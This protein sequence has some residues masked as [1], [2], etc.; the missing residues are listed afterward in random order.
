[1]TDRHEYC[2]NINI[3]TMQCVSIVCARCDKCTG[4]N[5]QGHYWSYCKVKQTNRDFH[6]CCPGDCELEND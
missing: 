1:M 5:S 2:H 3:L 4:N 6:F